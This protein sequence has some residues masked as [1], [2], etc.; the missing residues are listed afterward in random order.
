MLKISSSTSD[1]ILWVR[2]GCT[3]ILSFS[4]YS[5]YSTFWLSSS[6]NPSC[7]FSR[8]SNSKLVS[9]TLDYNTDF[10]V[11]FVTKYSSRVTSSSSVSSYTGSTKVASFFWANY[12]SRIF[13][14]A[15]TVVSISFS[16]IIF[17]I[18]VEV[19]LRIS[20]YY[21]HFFIMTIISLVF[22]FKKFLLMAGSL[23]WL[24]YSSTHF[25]NFVLASSIYLFKS[26]SFPWW[27]D[28]RFMAS[29]SNS[30]SF[31]SNSENLACFTLVRNYLKM[32]ISILFFYLTVSSL[33]LS[34][35]SKSKSKLS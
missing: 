4:F 25:S 29:S 5:Y 27:W 15:F 9:S 34:L 1:P 17:M 8:S 19:R 2:F 12:F 11:S 7:Y 16:L 23:N 6:N 13:F 35:C 22:S 18:S 10:L 28:L 30:L 32:G 3:K 20:V 21:F 31:R 24:L 14:L 33:L 26:L